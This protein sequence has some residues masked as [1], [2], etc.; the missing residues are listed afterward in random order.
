MAKSKTTWQ[1]IG[2]APKD[3]TVMAYRTFLWING[4]SGGLLAAAIV[5]QVDVTIVLCFACAGAVS[6]AAAIYNAPMRAKP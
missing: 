1:S 6:A 3:G 2:S 5:A 4:F